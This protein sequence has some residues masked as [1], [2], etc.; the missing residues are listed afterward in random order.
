MATGIVCRSRLIP[1]EAQVVHP[2]GRRWI[3][4]LRTQAV[5][6]A[7][8]RLNTNVTNEMRDTIHGSP[9][10]VAHLRSRGA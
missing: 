2:D 8:P 6:T 10:P 1:W 3:V 5:I 4:D 9:N 7:L